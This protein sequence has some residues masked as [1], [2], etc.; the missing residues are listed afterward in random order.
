MSHCRPYIRTVSISC[1]FSHCR[2]RDSDSGECPISATTEVWIQS[3]CRALDSTTQKCSDNLS[4]FL[5]KTHLWRYIFVVN[6][7]CLSDY[8]HR[9]LQF[10]SCIFWLNR[11]TKPCTIIT[12]PWG[13]P[14]F[15]MHGSTGR[16]CMLIISDLKNC[17]KISGLYTERILHTRRR[18]LSLCVHG[19]L[20]GHLIHAHNLELRTEV[21]LNYMHCA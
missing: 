7:S 11:L 14:L 5:T 6:W 16:G 13:R 20:V 15:E 12:N 3:V 1:V 4:R 9:L 21:S 8:V 10:K 19:F 18:N 2:G 17:W